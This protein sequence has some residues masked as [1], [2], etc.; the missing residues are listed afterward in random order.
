[1]KHL[2]GVPVYGRLLAVPNKHYIWRE[3]PV[4]LT[5]TGSGKSSYEKLIESTKIQQRLSL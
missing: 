1:V 3:R 5:D 4:L 2:S